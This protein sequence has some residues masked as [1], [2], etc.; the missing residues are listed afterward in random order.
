MKPNPFAF[1]DNVIDPIPVVGP[2]WAD[3]LY[4]FIGLADALNL[5][6]FDAEYAPV[7]TAENIVEL[8]AAKELAPLRK[9]A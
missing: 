9:A 4:T 8:H 1:I 6:H 2:I 5:Q 7:P 3:V